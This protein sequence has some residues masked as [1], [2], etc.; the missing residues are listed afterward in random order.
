MRELKL[1]VAD[2]FGPTGLRA[3]GWEF[4]KRLECR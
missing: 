1:V 4:G 3:L 2:R